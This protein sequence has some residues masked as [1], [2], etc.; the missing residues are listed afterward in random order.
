MRRPL[1]AV[2]VSAVP[3]GEPAAVHR[4]WPIRWFRVFEPEQLDRGMQL[5]A[6]AL[7]DLGPSPAAT[8]VIQAGG[9]RRPEAW[10]GA[11]SLAADRDGFAL[12]E[13]LVRS[14]LPWVGFAADEAADVLPAVEAAVG[15]RFDLT[16]EDCYPQ[17][18]PTA[19]KLLEVL[20]RSPGRW[21]LT[22]GSSLAVRRSANGEGEEDLLDVELSLIGSGPEGALVPSLLSMDASLSDNLVTVT[23][24]PVTGHELECLAAGARVGT[25]P[26]A[27]LLPPATVA[28]V[29]S[30]PLRAR[31]EWPMVRSTPADPRAAADALKATV[32]P[33]ALI[34]GG[35]GQGKTTLLHRWAVE[36]AEAGEA[37]LVVV[38]PH[39]D[40][41]VRIA[42]SLEGRGID[43]GVLDFGADD[44]LPWNLLVADEEPKAV[45]QQVAATI[46]GL[47]TDMPEEYFGPVWLRAARVLIEILVRDPAGPQ[48]LTR[49][50]EFFARSSRA[51]DEALRRID[52]P[53]LTLSVE[54]EIL[55]S[56]TARD[57]GHM[58][59][60]VTSKMEGLIGNPRVARIIGSTRSDVDLQPILEGHHTVVSAPMGRL[61]GDGSRL[62]ASLLIERLWEAGQKARLVRPVELFI[63]EWHRIPSQAIAALLAEGRKFGF[64]LRLANQNAAQIPRQLWETAL[65]NTGALAVFRTGPKDAALLDPVFPSVPTL[66]F[67]QL[68]RYWA[69]VATDGQDQV[70]QTLPP[71]DGCTDEGAIERGHQRVLAEARRSVLQQLG[72]AMAAYRDR[73]ADEPYTRE[74]AEAFNAW[75]VGLESREPAK[76]HSIAGQAQDRRRRLERCGN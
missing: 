36:T 51:R 14:L 50:P 55:P 70:V 24:H 63:D 43:F 6:G 30:I 67:T 29:L 9:G 40:L 5:L 26:P 38:D 28:R 69:A 22:V 32:P 33:H 37:T 13:S 34:V 21:Q 27:G 68:P 54:E 46:R 31:N 61:G 76:G 49:L 66:T 42:S 4:F 10:I 3:A 2:T 11:H 12:V 39:G 1:P 72:W 17:P 75:V 18:R 52:D 57:A 8:L 56:I 45:A 44:P 74:E 48:P 64:R 7:A 25:A 35:S 60:W 59:L 20:A 73:R 65:A 16:W 15:L 62:L 19:S 58:A 53:D 41:A 23:P 47:W 71:L